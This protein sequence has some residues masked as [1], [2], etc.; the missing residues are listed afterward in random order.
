MR[1]AFLFG[2]DQASDPELMSFSRL[3]FRRESSL[4]TRDCCRGVPWMMIC[5]LAAS[6]SVSPDA[7]CAS[8]SPCTPSASEIAARI[9]SVALAVMRIP[10]SVT[11][12]PLGSRFVR[13]Q[14]VPRN[15]AGAA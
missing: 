13:P 12:D 7:V 15:A 5:S 1:S 4:A 11:A 2:I 14:P 8:A 3:A 9:V 10:L 6:A